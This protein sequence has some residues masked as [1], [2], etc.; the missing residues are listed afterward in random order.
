VDTRTVWRGY[1]AI[2]FQDLAKSIRPSSKGQHSSPIFGEIELR[3]YLAA[4][5]LR[6][7]PKDQLVAPPPGLASTLDDVAQRQKKSSR[8]FSIHALKDGARALLDT[9]CC[10][11]WRGA[12]SLVQHF[13]DYGQI[14]L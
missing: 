8:P 9:I 6:A 1:D 11:A 12:P 4:I 14:N 3:K 7:D 2:S 5:C 13:P 10:G